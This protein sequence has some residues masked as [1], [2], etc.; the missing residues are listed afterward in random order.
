[1]TMAAKTVLLSRIGTLRDIA[2]NSNN[3]SFSGDALRQSLVEYNLGNEFLPR[4]DSVAS[5][6]SGR[7][8]T[9]RSMGFWTTYQAQIAF[10]QK[11]VLA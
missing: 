5:D 4:F 11:G 10:E 9:V 3:K 2:S 8:K 6:S 1:M 7:L